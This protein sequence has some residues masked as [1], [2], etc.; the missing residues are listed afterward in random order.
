[1]AL[2]P[3]PNNKN[4]ESKELEVHVVMC[5]YRRKVIED[6]I[7]YLEKQIEDTNTRAM[8]SKKL[9]L[10]AILSVITGVITTIFSIFLNYNFLKS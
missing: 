9:I 3:V 10:G 4:I 1:M 2:I 7:E 8:M 5:E 6:K